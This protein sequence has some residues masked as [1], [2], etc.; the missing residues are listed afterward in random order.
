[1]FQL[2]A[3]REEKG[4]RKFKKRFAVAKQAKVGCFMLKIDGDGP[5]FSWL[6]G[7]A[8]HTSLPGQMVCTA[9][10]TPWG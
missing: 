8:S 4:E 7:L 1:M 10:D 5:V 6:F 9:Q 2:K 3:K